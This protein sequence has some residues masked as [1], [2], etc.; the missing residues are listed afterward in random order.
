MEGCPGRRAREAGADGAGATPMSTMTFEEAVRSG[1]EVERAAAA[2]YR[3]LARNT[4]CE[5][6]RPFLEKLAA[7]EDEHAAAIAELGRR[8]GAGDLPEQACECFEL[9]ETAPEWRYEDGI[10]VYGALVIAREAEIHAALFY[11]AVGDA[12]TGKVAS[13]FHSLAAT[14]ELHVRDIEQLAREL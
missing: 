12:A 13:F 1:I 2:F 5:R 7:Q 8:M 14:E 10:T 11:R 9:V 3:A 6:A 4:A